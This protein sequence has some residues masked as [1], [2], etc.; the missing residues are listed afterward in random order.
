M[1]GRKR[2]TAPEDSAAQIEVELEGVP[3]EITEYGSEFPAVGQAE[4]NFD[5]SEGPYDIAEVDLATENVLDVGAIKLRLLP[6]VSVRVEV[7]QTS[8]KPIAVTLV[9]GQGAVQV[10]A[11]AAPRSGGLWVKSRGE[12]HEQIRA[13]GGQAAE[14]R[15][16]FG[17]EVH[18]GMPA[19]GPDGKTTGLQP[20]RF[21]GIEGPRWLIQG[22]FMGEGAVPDAAAA[23]EEALKTVIVDRGAEPLPAG[24]MLP[25]T[26]PQQPTEEP[27]S[28]EPAS[29]PDPL[30]PGARITETR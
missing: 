4:G 30:E 8:K 27:A 10:R 22:I 29:T 18:A 21:V 23:V 5:R 3:E 11:F 26:L 12:L 2:K 24:A 1:F 15:G 6:E 14:V 28:P 17:D 19:K 7:D 16:T 25:L 13:S 9:R 20:M